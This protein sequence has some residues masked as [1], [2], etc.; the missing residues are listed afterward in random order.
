LSK[1][2]DIPNSNSISTRFI[3]AI[4]EPMIV[5]QFLDEGGSFIAVRLKFQMR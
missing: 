2:V 4:M 3:A 1:I 5:S